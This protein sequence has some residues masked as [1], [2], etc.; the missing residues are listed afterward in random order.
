MGGS[1]VTKTTGKTL[2]V[3]DVSSIKDHIST[4][5]VQ[6]KNSRGTD[7]Y[8]YLQLPLNK[9]EAVRE[10]LQA[11]E[12]FIPSNYGTVLAAGMGEPSAEIR[13]EFGNIEFMLK[14]EPKRLPNL[15]V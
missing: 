3:D 1:W 7:I 9:V 11:G 4:L 14:F 5:L 12:P 2:P 10:V 13:S 8:C 15:P 6:A